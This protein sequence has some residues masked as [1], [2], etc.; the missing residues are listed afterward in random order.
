MENSE[1]FEIA[2][3]HEPNIVVCSLMSLIK[4]LIRMETVIFRRLKRL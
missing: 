1:H 3:K 4:V 2:V